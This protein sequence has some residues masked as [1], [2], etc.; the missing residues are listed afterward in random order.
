MIDRATKAEVIASLSTAASY[1]RAAALT[2]MRYD[3]CSSEHVKQIFG[4]ANMITEDW[5]PEIEGEIE[6]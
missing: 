3:G 6:A 4:A 2:M 5:I 1:M